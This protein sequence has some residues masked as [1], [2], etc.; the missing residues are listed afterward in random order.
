MKKNKLSVIL[1]ALA[2]A[3]AMITTGCGRSGGGSESSEPKT[4]ETYAAEHSDI[5]KEIDEA[6]ANSNTSGVKVQ[7]EG[8]DIVYYF[9]LSQMEGYT[10]EIAKSETVLDAL[11][12][13]LETEAATFGGIAQNMETVTGLSGIKTVVNYNWGDEVLV[14]KTFTDKDAVTAEAES[15]DKDSSSEEKSSEE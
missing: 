12:K 3:A 2:I 6:V 11:E 9:D 1:L 5:Q 8:N 7:I 10:E 15:E 14:T 13:S 4:L